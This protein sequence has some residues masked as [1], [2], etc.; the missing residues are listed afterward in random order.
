MELGQDHLRADVKDFSP[1]QQREFIASW[2][3]SAFL[4]EPRGR[5]DHT[6]TWEAG[7]KQ[8]AALQAKRVT[9]YLALPEN[10]AIRQLAAV[11]LLL[12]I[13]AVIWKERGFR[14]KTRVDL[15]R[16]VMRYLLEY[17]DSTRGLDPLLSA[18]EALRVL[19]P[20]ALWMQEELR[21]DDIQKE[22][23][24]TRMAGKITAINH[25]VSPEAFC[26][27]LRDR[28][29]IIADY[30]NTGYIFR[31]KSFREYLAGMEITRG[32][33]TLARFR[34]LAVYLGNPWWAETLRFF[35]SH[36][37]EDQFDRFM[38]AV[39]ERPASE[40]LDMNTQGL[41]RIMVAEACEKKTDSL[42][43]CLAG[44]DDQGGASRKQC[45]L[46]CLK[47][48]DSPDAWEAICA[49]ARTNAVATDYARELVVQRSGEE[50]LPEEV[51]VP[52]RLPAQ[53]AGSFRNPYEL[54]A[55]YILIP[56]G[57]FKYDVTEEVVPVSDL[58]FAK[59]PVT[60]KR[61]RRFIEYL[62]DQGRELAEVLPVQAFGDQLLKSVV[63][64]PG[65]KSYLG[66]DCDTW[67]EKLRSSKDDDRRFGGDDQPV[68]GVSWF[69][70]RAYC[71]WLTTLTKA[72]ARS[73]G[74]DGPG[75]YRLPA[76]TEWFWAAAGRGAGG[77]LRDYPWPPKKGGPTDKLAN[78]GHNVGATTPVGSYPE[79][80]TP[81][82]LMD[83]A[84]NVWEWMDNW[85]E[86]Y[87]DKARSLR[88][89]SWYG[90]G[91]IL[92]CSAR[93]NYFPELRNDG[94]GFRVVCSQS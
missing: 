59:Y 45:I 42:A 30:G 12:Q 56:G 74:T 55:E 1:S 71:F 43:A 57:K 91:S 14:P 63:D 2:F 68:V 6:E 7:Q 20:V 92:R 46:D 15:F 33:L 22:E 90:Y 93:L 16:A 86:E 19:R 25:N 38:K 69:A 4:K 60:N 48:I 77:E 8:K 66:E 79:G 58:Y 51:A 70:A 36:V 80:A 72:M 47:I 34:R 76:E 32:N 41:L 73:S 67:A 94:I 75:L 18:E 62:A 10:K 40:D 13:I 85:H 26:K 81:E 54:N 65:F 27:N 44:P 87:T 50:L 23:A 78:Y 24:H 61:Y 17:R 3:E 64:I 53:G 37:D 29:G 84:G 82:G 35:L 31:H 28:A 49:Y 11:P 21:A 5:R 83:V 89:G 9:D 39:F 52:T 88:G